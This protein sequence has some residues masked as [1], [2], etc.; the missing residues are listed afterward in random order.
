MTIIFLPSEG[1]KINNVLPV[2]EINSLEKKLNVLVKC[3]FSNV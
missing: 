2:K 1:I 3:I